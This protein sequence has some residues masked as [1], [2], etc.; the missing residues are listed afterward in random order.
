MSIRFYP[1]VI[2]RGDEPGFGVFFPDFPGCV[3]AG[4]TMQQAALNAEEALRGHVS[5]M[6]SDGDAIPQPSS[7]DEVAC[8]PEIR[9]A[10]RLLVRL[11]LPGELIAA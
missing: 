7:L 1:A 8:D 4:D 6:L 5:L 10:A 3:S 2:E 9:E 11:E